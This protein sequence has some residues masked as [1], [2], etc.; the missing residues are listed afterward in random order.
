MRLKR[1]INRDGW[2]GGQERV[3]GSGGGGGGDGDG[4]GEERG[5]TNANGEQ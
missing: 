5:T 4:G 2:W 3:R 1:E